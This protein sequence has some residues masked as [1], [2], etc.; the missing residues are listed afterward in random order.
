M[1]TVLL[2]ATLLLVNPAIAQQ[3]GP[4]H[5]NP[6]AQSA[7]PNSALQHQ[8]EDKVAHE[9]ALHGTDIKINVENTSVSLT[10]TVDTEQ[11]HNLALGIA[12]S[13]AGDRTID[14]KI[15]VRGKT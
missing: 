9:P 4:P 5:S 10:G 2:G 11:Q 15:Q 7:L 6:P 8:I 3:Q 1:K 14:D 13:L 12:Q